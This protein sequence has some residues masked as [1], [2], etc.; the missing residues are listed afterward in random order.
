MKITNEV[1]WNA[2]ENFAKILNDAFQKRFEKDNM[3][4]NKETF[5]KVVGWIVESETKKGFVANCA[6]IVKN[7]P[8]ISDELTKIVN[9]VITLP[10]ANWADDQDIT[11]EMFL[12]LAKFHIEC[13]KPN[14]K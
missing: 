7:A 12:A 1:M 14:W 5:I 4:T 2:A 8:G 11:F 9:M 10:L 13:V 3:L 6:T